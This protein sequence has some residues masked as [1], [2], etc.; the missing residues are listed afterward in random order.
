MLCDKINMFENNILT[1]AKEGYTFIICIEMINSESELVEKY[2]KILNKN[3]TF[4]DILRRHKTN[5]AISRSLFIYI[6][7]HAYTKY[8]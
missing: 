5:S 7:K 8:L 6:L 1:N 2:S 4:I 3:M